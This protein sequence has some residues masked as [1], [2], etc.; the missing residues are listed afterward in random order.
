MSTRQRRHSLLVVRQHPRNLHGGR[1]SKFYMPRS[2]DIFHSLGCLGSS[3]P[4][5]NVSTR[6]NLLWES[7]VF[8]HRRRC[9]DP[10]VCSGKT[11]SQRPDQT[12]EHAPLL[13][14]YRSHSTR[15]SHQV[16]P[17]LHYL[18]VAMQPGRSWDL[19]SIISLSGGILHGGQNTSLVLVLQI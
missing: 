5:A 9:P 19:S 15:D 18:M 4:T 11:V 2:G 3:R 12:I 16:R 14:R 10:L 13:F 7:L 6:P 17:T 1:R 8:P